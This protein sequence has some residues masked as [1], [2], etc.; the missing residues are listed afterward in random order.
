VLI[1]ECPSSDPPVIELE[2]HR[3]LIK[4]ATSKNKIKPLEKS[5]ASGADIFEKDLRC[6]TTS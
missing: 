5:C 6:I 1:C 4:V 2:M 3:A